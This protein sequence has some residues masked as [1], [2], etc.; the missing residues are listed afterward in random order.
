MPPFLDDLTSAAGFTLI[1]WGFT[2]IF[3]GLPS[4]THHHLTAFLLFC[5]LLYFLG[6]E[7][8]WFRDRRR[9]KRR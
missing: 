6:G 5:G 2:S 4:F 7:D 9:R 3:G 8:R 1:M